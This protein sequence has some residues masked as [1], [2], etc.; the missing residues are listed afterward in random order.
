MGYSAG[1]LSVRQRRDL[2][3]QLVGE[4]YEKLRVPEFGALGYSCFQ[5]FGYLITADGLEDHLRKS[6]RLDG[7]TLQPPLPIQTTQQS[8]TCKVPESEAPSSDNV[9][10]QQNSNIP[11]TLIFIMRVIAT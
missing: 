5:K 4:A 2:I 11:E 1:K 7:Y 9:K 6:A 8:I 10:D 3:T